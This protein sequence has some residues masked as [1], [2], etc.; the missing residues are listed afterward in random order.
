MLFDTAYTERLFDMQARFPADRAGRHKLCLPAGG[1]GVVYAPS[2]MSLTSV[3]FAPRVN[4]MVSP[5]WV[6]W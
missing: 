3:F 5:S 4:V 1:M 2:R 6:R